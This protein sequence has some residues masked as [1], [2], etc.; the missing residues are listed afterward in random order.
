SDDTTEATVPATVTIPAG[1]A[2]VDFTITAVDDAIIDG[3][4]TAA[5][6][7]SAATFSDGTDDIDVTDDETA[8]VSIAA[9]GDGFEAGPVDAQFTVTLS[10]V[11]AVDI[12]VPYTLGGSAISGV[13]YSPLSGSVTIPAG[14][15]SAM[16][17]AEVIDDEVAEIGADTLSVTLQEPVFSGNI[18]VD[19][20][21]DS[22]QVLILDNDTATISLSTVSVTVDETGAASSATVD[23]TLDSRPTADV[24]IAVT[25]TDAGE[26]LPDTGLL[27]FTPDNWNVPQTV[28]INGQADGVADGVQLANIEFSIDAATAAAEYLTTD[29]STFVTTTVNDV[30]TAPT[31]DIESI[32]FYNEDAVAE[33]NFSPDQTGQ[34][35]IVRRAEVVISDL[36]GVAD[37]TAFSLQN[38]DT[39]TDVTVTLGGVV[40]T[41]GKTI[42]TLD[43]SG[44]SVDTVN[45]L[46]DGN[47]QLQ[48]DGDAL[49]VTGGAQSE[50]FHRLFGDSDGDRDVDGSDLSNLV[51]GLYFGATQFNAVFDLNDN[52]SLF[53]EIDDFFANFGRSL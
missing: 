20:T 1:M 32:V 5:I 37:A 6:T 35:S 41:G 10:S 52:D 39:T 48:I 47:Y 38:V 18:T 42:V 27:T 31:A 2:A 8:T 19:G 7:A 30:D 43:F 22:A 44:G 12:E 11:A 13:D 14:S 46:L 9:A 16:I 25:S 53:D 29:D 26:A 3:T 40:Q 36:L 34:R 17:A 23:V 50:D 21:A 24:V 49:G 33:R 15:L 51:G 4:Q 45:G 28:T